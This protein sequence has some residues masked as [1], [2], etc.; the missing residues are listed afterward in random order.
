MINYFMLV[1]INLILGLCMSRK[2]S[3]NHIQGMFESLEIYVILFSFRKE[4][5]NYK[6]KMSSVKRLSRGLIFNVS[7]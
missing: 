3:Y 1:L 7:Q 5:Y 2:F 4:N 6:A